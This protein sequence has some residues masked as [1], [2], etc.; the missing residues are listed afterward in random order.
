MMSQ[1]R[2]QIIA[3]HIMPN[4]LRSKGSQTIKF[5]QLVKHNTRN[6]F[7]EK[8]FT[9]CGG[10]TIPDPFL[11]SQNQ[12]YLWINSLKVLKSLFLLNANLRAIEI[13]WNETAD[14][15]FYLT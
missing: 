9:K 11:Q 13:K 6:I 2:Y 10:E 5:H 1:P 15:S 3:V 14:Y 8:W 7:V 12:V 4:I